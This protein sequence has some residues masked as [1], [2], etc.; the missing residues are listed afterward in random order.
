MA[1]VGI[2]ADT[3]KRNCTVSGCS[4]P[5]LARGLCAM[6]YQRLKKHGSI[7]PVGKWHPNLDFIRRIDLSS[8]NCILWPFG[9]GASGKGY[10]VLRY[11][12][13]QT[14][15]H[16]V[17][18]II[19]QGH[20]PSP[21]HEAAHDPTLCSSILC[22]N[23]KHLRW[24]T[25]SENE[26]DKA[27]RGTIAR[28]TVASTSSL[29]EEDVLKIAASSGDPRAAAIRYGVH[30]ATIKR[31]RSG[32]SWSWLTGIHSQNQSAS[33]RDHGPI[34]ASTLAPAQIPDARSAPPASADRAPPDNRPSR[35]P[36]G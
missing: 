12:G 18:L 4:S 17:S 13:R 33:P 26:A 16:R 29:T 6:H 15:A 34:T 27:E 1:T 14:T 19:H 25:R 22:I 3:P 8:D 21:R 5:H 28:G 32:Y 30:V 9:R 23:P 35:P 11:A 36:P 2:S 31:I 20:P 24:A 10:G 7:N